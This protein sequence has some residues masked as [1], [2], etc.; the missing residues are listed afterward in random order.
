MANVR[1]LLFIVLACL[2]FAVGVA[3]IGPEAALAQCTSGGCGGGGDGGGDPQCDPENPT[4]E[5]IECCDGFWCPTCY[6]LGPDGGVGQIDCDDCGWWIEEMAS[7][8]TPQGHLCWESEPF[9]CRDNCN[10]GDP[11]FIQLDKREVNALWRRLVQRERAT[12][13]KK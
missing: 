10:S 2:L 11:S 7:P 6:V 4:P 8:H 9:I 3:V 1:R 13:S 12:Q 5:C